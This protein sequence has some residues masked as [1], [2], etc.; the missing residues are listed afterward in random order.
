MEFKE[1]VRESLGK[2][3]IF[4]RLVNGLIAAVTRSGV[5]PISALKVVHIRCE[6]RQDET[7]AMQY[8]ICTWIDRVNV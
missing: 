4:N 6:A 7:G 8:I 3:A 1:P 2:Y 5:R